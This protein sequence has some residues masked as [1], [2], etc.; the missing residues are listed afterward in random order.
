[1]IY[2]ER[3]DSDELINLDNIINMKETL[4][5]IEQITKKYLSKIYQKE[6]S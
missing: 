3:R 5:N 2:N 6:V 1:M 4:I